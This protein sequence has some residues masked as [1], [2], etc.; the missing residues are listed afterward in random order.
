MIYDAWLEFLNYILP[1]TGSNKELVYIGMV[2]TLILVVLLFKG[3][4]RK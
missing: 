1:S 2:L 3:G 4:K